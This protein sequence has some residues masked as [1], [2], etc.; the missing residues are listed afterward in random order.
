[1]VLIFTFLT[2]NS[3][4]VTSN[5]VAF[6]A[7][8]GLTFLTKPLKRLIVF[9]DVKLRFSQICALQV[10]PFVAIITGYTVAIFR[11]FSAAR[12]TITGHAG[13]GG[14]RVQPTLLT[15]CSCYG[16]ETF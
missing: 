15:Q 5:Y 1:M 12:R 7:N 4:I 9:E 13:G 11:D 3:D 14:E 6:S 10:V 8:V 16:S 2:L